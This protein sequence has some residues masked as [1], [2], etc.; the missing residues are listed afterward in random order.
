MLRLN[1]VILDHIVRFFNRAD[2]LHAVFKRFIVQIVQH[3]VFRHFLY[4]AESF[5]FQI[6]ILW[7]I[8]DVEFR[9]LHTDEI[10]SAEF[11]VVPNLFD[12]EPT[13]TH[14]NKPVDNICLIYGRGVAQRQQSIVSP[15]KQRNVILIG[16]LMR[17]DDREKCVR[18]D[19]IN[20]VI[21]PVQR[22]CR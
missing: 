11:P 2:I 6:I 19:N 21:I 13:V 7:L 20:A 1:L 17:S 12:S 10:L 14:L 18:Y 16:L 22:R 4:M 5:G 3:P 15:T 9:L 8:D